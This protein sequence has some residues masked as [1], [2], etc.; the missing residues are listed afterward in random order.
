MPAGFKL[1]RNGDLTGFWSG[2]YWYDLTVTPIPFSAHIDDTG[3]ALTGTTLEP[4]TF[5]APGLTELSADLRG[6]RS[7]PSLYFSKVYHPAPGV[8]RGAI[9]YSGVT[10]ENFTCV[11]GDWRFPDGFSGRFVMYRASFGQTVEASQEL[12][13]A[14]PRSPGRP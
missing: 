13:A 10:N 14:N 2:E 12:A 1:S 9:H 3:G 11:E 5:G 6:G 7:G 4:A 8:H